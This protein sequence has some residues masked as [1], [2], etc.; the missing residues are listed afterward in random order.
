MRV[1]SGTV[2]EGELRETVDWRGVL[3]DRGTLAYAD[4][5]RIIAGVMLVCLCACAC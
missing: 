3:V 1:R 5:N 4:A 2:V